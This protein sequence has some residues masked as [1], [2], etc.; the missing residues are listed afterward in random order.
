MQNR[1]YALAIGTVAVAGMLL[2]PIFYFFKWVQHA[3]WAGIAA[4]L[5]VSPA[6]LT[7]VAL[8]VALAWGAHSAAMSLRDSAAPRQPGGTGGLMSTEGGLRFALWLYLACTA[9]AFASRILPNFTGQESVV[10]AGV[11][12]HWVVT[13]ILV[14]GFL[15]VQIVVGLAVLCESRASDPIK[16]FAVF[17]F[18]LSMGGKLWQ[19]SCTAFFLVQGRPELSAH[20]GQ[21]E[22]GAL[23]GAALW[24][25]IAV[26]AL[27]SPLRNW[28]AYVV[29]IFC[30]LDVLRSMFY[31][32]L[33]MAQ[34]SLGYGKYSG[35]WIEKY[36]E[37][38]RSKAVG[39]SLEGWGILLDLATIAFI[40][41]ALMIARRRSAAKL[42]PADARTG[43][44]FSPVGV[45]IAAG[46]AWTFM[47]FT[48]VDIAQCV[49]GE[50]AWSLAVLV[51]A[52]IFLMILYFSLWR[53]LAESASKW[54]IPQGKLAALLS[55]VLLVSYFV[56]FLMPGPPPH[57]W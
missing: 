7:A 23:A 56:L 44:V 3:G 1:K 16:M 4:G 40:Y 9:A 15:L 28:A 37:F 46:L 31:L 48:P 14:M 55:A 41:Y 54:L 51:P 45:G 49:S 12:L 42:V 10:S 53:L 47:H 36:H 43:L 8:L 50:A 24:V 22:L 35:S 6:Q 33:G 32:Y 26:Q 21:S 17:L 19:L 34:A 13:D 52:G 2:I 5:A 18:S 38:M 25:V 29:T 11:K 57:N 27:R 30:A 20:Y 39:W